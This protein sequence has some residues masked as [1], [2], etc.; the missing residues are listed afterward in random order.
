MLEIKRISKIY[1]TSGFKQKALDGVSI[2]F[3]QS[4][5][6]S[7]LGPSG[8]G[9]TTLLNIIG[10]LDKYTSGDL[11]INGISTK[12]YNDRDWDTYRNHKVGFVFQSYN[13]I[14]H[15]TVLSNVELALTL[16][17]VSKV[18]RRKLAKD[19]LIK[20]GLKDHINKKPNQLSGGQMQ[21]VAIARAL[22]NDPDILLA[23]EPTGALDSKTSTQIMEILKS[24][25]NDRLVIMVTHNADLAKDYSTRVIELKDGVIKSDSKP[26]KGEKEESE[27]SRKSKTKMSFKTALELS[28]N[29]LMTKKG[30]TILVAF[31]G[32]I[33]IIGIALISALSTGF[34]NY[35]DKLQEDTL[36]SYPLTI[37]QESTDITGMLLSMTSG[38]KT[39]NNS[40]SV[41]EKQYISSMLSNIKANDL[42]SFKSY[43]EKNYDKVKDD[44]TSV[45]YSYSIDPLIYTK[46]SKGNIDRLNPNNLFSQMYGNSM[47]NSY[48]SFASIFNQMIDDQQTLDEEYDVLAGSWPKKYNEMV[49]VLNEPNSIPDLLVYSLGLKDN[50]ELTDMITK[51]MSG[52]TVEEVSEAQT[53]TYD[54]LMNVE[55]KLI[56]P[57]D[58][59]KYN[60]KY[61][62]YEDMSEDKAYMENLYKESI[63]LKIVGI[64]C[65]KEESNSMAL[66]SGVAYTSD[67]IDYIIDYARSTDIVKKQLSFQNIDVF[68]NNSFD[69]AN[70]KPKIDFKDM[71]SVDTNKLQSAFN[72][73]INQSD[74]AKSTEGYMNEISA[75]ITTD[76]KPAY[77]DFMNGL[78]KLARG[79]FSSINGNISMNDIDATVSNYINSKEAINVINGLSKYVLPN[80]TYNKTYTGL[81]KGVL[82]VYISSYYLV[83]KS[84][85]EDEKNPTAMILD[86]ITNEVISKYKE[87]ADV[88]GTGDTMAKYMTEALMKKTI[89][90]K[91][92]E[93]TNKMS[94]SI[95]SSFHVDQ[96]KIASA[97]KFNLTEKELARIMNAM[98]NNDKATANSNLISLG[99][100][101]KDN[102]TYISFYFESFDGKED[103][104]D[105]IDSYNKKME[106]S[107]NQD[108]VLNYSDT[109]GIL[110]GSV[111]KIVNSVSYVLIAFVSISLVVSSIMIGIITYIS[112]YERTKEIGILRAIGASKRN[113]SSIFN[114]ETFI[115]GFLSGLIGI[116][117]T[118]SLIPLINYTIHTL[119][120]NK[121]ISATLGLNESL[122]LI[123]LSIILT[124]IG[125]LIPSKAASKKDPVVALRSE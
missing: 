38:D 24:V 79:L 46:N 116:G 112:V 105:F 123:I 55:L 42:K 56:N 90:T 117:V 39:N 4:E 77:N 41:V 81:L 114:A 100:Q 78:D 120:N 92:G 73:N 1:D 53:F 22:V 57:A 59:Y 76:T 72:I 115:I 30:R 118:Y 104:I 47:M 102:P 122:I 52:E 88:I 91:V 65:A 18:Q 16:S 97:F 93:L 7:I 33:G 66:S 50:K 19:A 96:N 68:S 124:L 74:I 26:Y 58:I 99:Y 5:F 87:N 31:A 43:F 3:R 80:K 69:E 14:P 37:M 103:F 119:T 45:K 89:L 125:G 9:K 17:G 34:Q 2:N 13:L 21:R 113:I 106:E 6:V 84:L 29:N 20:V 71:I 35:I 54:D 62:I 82:Q 98:N 23:D 8:S 85:T 36:S 51:I 64:V 61:K 101:D 70:A 63:N 11:I 12:E 60:S 10:G 27:I 121:S 25:A 28:F 86:D 109:T 67:L 95:A 48:S 111:K 108:K 40:N 75:S 83:D 15:Q 44:L 107:D 110:M 32:S 49:L 94:S